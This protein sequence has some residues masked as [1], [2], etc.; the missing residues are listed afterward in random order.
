MTSLNEYKNK[1][2]EEAFE[3]E[4]SVYEEVDTKLKREEI[5]TKNGGGPRLTNRDLLEMI[6]K[7][8]NARN[9]T[10]EKIKKYK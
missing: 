8:G 4:E 1:K 10:K 7:M 9:E 3:R 5:R 6:G 2:I